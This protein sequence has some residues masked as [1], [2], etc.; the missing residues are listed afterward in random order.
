MTTQTSAAS[1]Q[2]ERELNYYR[3]ECND[4]GA[5]LLRLQEE[6]SQAF[7]DARRSRTTAKLMREAY[8]LADTASSVEEISGAL[9]EVIVDNAMC[10]RAAFL[11]EQPSGSA[12]FVVTHAVGTPGDLPSAATQ[13][14]QVP[15]FFFTTSQTRIEP[16]AYELTGIL[17]L[18]YILWSYDRP[19]GRALILGNR[20]ESNVSRPF[21]E[22]DQ[23][24]IEGA[25]SVYL[26][27]LARKQAE[28]QLQRAK[29]AA[30]ETVEATVGFLGSIGGALRTPLNLII[31]NSEKMSSGSRYPLTLERCAEFAD[32][33]HESGV[34]LITVINDILEYS[35]FAKRAVSH[36]MQ[37]RSLAEIVAPI[38][39]S[40][41]PGGIADG[42]LCDAEGIDDGLEVHVDEAVFRQALKNLVGNASRATHPTGTLQLLANVRGDGS[43]Q[44]D[45]E[46]VRG[47]TNGSNGIAGDARSGADPNGAVGAIT[48]PLVRS[49]IDAHEGSLHI[50]D[51][52]GHRFHAS[53]ALPAHR[54][55]R[56]THA[57]EHTLS[58]GN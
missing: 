51:Q 47:S 46:A 2:L 3:R 7:R 6:Q 17:K 14:Y 10:D 8:R 54:L 11:S 28:L 22:G 52:S 36:E 15:N 4:L 56:R 18:P 35:S 40:A 32:H 43:L 55:R 12:S 25:L 23:E 33:I 38:A 34:R 24:L 5:R 53:I 41:I 13:I 57:A 45:V 30:E 21:E 1:A 42:M 39:S 50:E 20:S 49:L 48:L 26:D 37:W 16:P 29:R 31:G 44:I 27:V 19:S 58:D 9:L